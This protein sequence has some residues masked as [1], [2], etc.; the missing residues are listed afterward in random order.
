MEPSKAHSH[1][2]TVRIW[3]EVL[4]GSHAEWRGKVQHITTGEIRYVREWSTLPSLLLDML[5][6]VRD[7]QDARQ[8]GTEMVDQ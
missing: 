8:S 7:E 3:D 4:E 5:A 6:Q 2:F 1:L